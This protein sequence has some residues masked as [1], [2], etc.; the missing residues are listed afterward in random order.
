MKLMFLQLGMTF[1]IRVG[2][3]GGM[4]ALQNSEYDVTV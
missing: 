2:N 4:S 1:A 3:Y